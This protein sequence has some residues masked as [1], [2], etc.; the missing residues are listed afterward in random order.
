MTNEE[1]IK[2]RN[3]LNHLCETTLLNKG[4]EYTVGSEDRLANFKSLSKSLGLSPLQVWAVYWKKH[5][6]SILNYVREGKTHSEPI[7]MRF[8]DCRNYI[9]LGLALINDA[10]IN[11]KDHDESKA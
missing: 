2:V 11:P 5:V 10:N 8:V 3:S 9:D 1:F 7:H 6:D 4:K